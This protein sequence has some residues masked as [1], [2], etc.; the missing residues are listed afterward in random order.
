V[1][2]IKATIAR[3]VNG[4]SIPT[5]MHQHAT[6]EELLEALFS[7]QSVP[8]L[9]NEATNIATFRQEIISGGKSHKGTPYQD[10]LTDC[11]S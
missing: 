3:E 6:I 1:E 5:A 11:Q 10:V 4:K 7:M 2:S 8:R 9:H